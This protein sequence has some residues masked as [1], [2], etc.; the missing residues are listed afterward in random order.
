MTAKGS[1]RPSSAASRHASAIPESEAPTLSA[2]LGASPAEGR[3]RLVDQ[4][5]PILVVGDLRLGYVGHLVG[6][7]DQRFPKVAT[8]AENPCEKRQSR[9]VVA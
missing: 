8:A 4:L 7:V 9:R 6:Q 1:S 3:E 5:V 2:T